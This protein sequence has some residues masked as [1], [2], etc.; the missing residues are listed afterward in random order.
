MSR[1][2]T[3]RDAAMVAKATSWT[4]ALNL[5][6]QAYPSFDRKSIQPEEGT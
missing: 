5:H 2:S 4:C 1:R 6:G 3:E